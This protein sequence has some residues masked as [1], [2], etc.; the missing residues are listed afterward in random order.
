MRSFAATAALASCALVTSTFAS[1]LVGDGIQLLSARDVFVDSTSNC[2][3]IVYGAKS[4]PS[5]NTCVGITEGTLTVTANVAD[6]WVLKDVH[7]LISTSEFTTAS[8]TSPGQF[9]YGIHKGSCI[10]SGLMAT[11]TIPMRPEW[12]LCDKPLHVAVHVAATTPTGAS[13][14]GWGK[15]PCYDNKG[16]CAKYW[17]FNTA[18]TCPVIYDFEP[19]T[20][21]VSTPRDDIAVICDLS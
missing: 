16:N 7:I 1:P 8:E 19:I 12:R 6:K 14:T 5:G 15:G 20:T 13:E 2:R 3:A 21:T 17:T 18:C 10:K 11:C 4:E 9:P